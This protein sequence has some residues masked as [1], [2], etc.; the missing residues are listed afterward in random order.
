M[1]DFQYIRKFR[2]KIRYIDAIFEMDAEGRG[3]TKNALLLQDQL[4]YS[5][6]VNKSRVENNNHFKLRELQ[7]WIVRN[8]KHIIEYYDK[9]TH[10]I[11]TPY[12]NRVHAMEER[13]ND[14]F[15]S[16]IQ[17]GLISKV[18]TERAEKLRGMVTPLYGFT[19][20]GILLRLIIE[21]MELQKV[22]AITKKQDAIAILKK[23]LNK[24]NQFIYNVL[25]LMFKIRN[26]SSSATIFYSTFFRRC[27][28]KG[29]FDKLVE[30]IHY[31]INSNHGIQSVTDPLVRVVD[32]GFQGSQ[33]QIDFLDLWYGTIKELVPE[34]RKLLLYRLKLHFENMFEQ[35]NAPL[36]KRYEEFRFDLR[37]NYERI[38]VE[39][40]C[41]NCYHKEYLGLHYRTYLK[42]TLDGQ[43]CLMKV[44]CKRCNTKGTMIVSI[45]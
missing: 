41:K 45:L 40:V 30:H 37:D 32:R 27:E 43:K 21:S 10:R 25:D 11:H 23:E 24:I 13:I 3:Y 16:L 38:A 44:E 35:N 22:M 9:S 6:V 1:I 26:D 39:A 12:S 19:K 33:S 20:S 2:Q 42:W 34:V 8:N 15:Q 28:D 14:K 7:N 18:G 31:I 4:K 29:I 5:M 17:T 36:N